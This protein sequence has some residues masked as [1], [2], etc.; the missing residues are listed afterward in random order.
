MDTRTTYQLRDGQEVIAHIERDTNGDGK[1]DVFETYDS[2]K[3]RP[4]L[5]KRE[6]D[7]NGDGRVDVTSVYENGKLKSRE[8]SDPSLVPL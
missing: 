4:V 5:T 6:E 3:G 1:P 7:K 2:L 8:I